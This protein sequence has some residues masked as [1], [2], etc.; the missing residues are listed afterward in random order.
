MGARGFA[1]G[2]RGARELLAALPCLL[3]LQ[4]R[5]LP[6][7]SGQQQ[8]QQQQK[9]KQQPAGLGSASFANC[10]ALSP[11]LQMHYTV[12]GDMLDMVL[13]GK[14]RDPTADSW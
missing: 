7:V 1:R 3:L 2:G 10:V 11:N 8:Q 4:L 14:L 6:L 13:E 5:A 9:Q 12:E